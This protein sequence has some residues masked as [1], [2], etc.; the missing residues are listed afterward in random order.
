[1]RRLGYFVTESS[2]H[3]AEYV[4][5]F[6]KPDRPELIERFNIP[7]D[8]YIARC[9]RHAA[10]HDSGTCDGGGRSTSS[11]RRVRRRHHPGVRDRRAVPLQRQRPE[12]TP[13]GS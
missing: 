11:E 8:E 12:P 10:G 1:M 13:A 7:L 6:I 3:F 9:E 4:P 2:E 5:W